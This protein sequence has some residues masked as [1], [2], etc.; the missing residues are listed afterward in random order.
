MFFFSFRFDLFTFR[1]RGREGEREGENINV[2]LPLTNPLLEIWETQACAPTENQTCEPL[3]HRPAL[4]P[5]SHT[6]QGRN[7]LIIKILQYKMS[8][9][10]NYTQPIDS[11]T[12]LLIFA[13]LLLSCSNVW[14]P[15]RNQCNFMNIACYFY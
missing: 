14:L 8:F 6:S 13:E 9:T 10:V 5:L 12:I 1:Q 11:H 15:L 7:N 4:N 3:V 2:W